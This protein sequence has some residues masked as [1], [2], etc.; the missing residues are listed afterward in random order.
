MSMWENFKA[1]DHWF[2]KRFFG[3]IFL[4]AITIGLIFLIDKGLDK[5]PE[6]K[7]LFIEYGNGFIWFLIAGTVLSIFTGTFYFSTLDSW[8]DETEKS[9]TAASLNAIIWSIFWLC[10]SI[11]SAWITL[12]SKLLT[13]PVVIFILLLVVIPGFAAFKFSHGVRLQELKQNDEEKAR[14]GEKYNDCDA[15]NSNTH[16]KY[17]SGYYGLICLPVYLISLPLIYLFK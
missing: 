10:W 16:W 15:Y 3:V 13:I 9:I 5:V 7:N 6:I 11:Y 14:I 8:E 2:E 4:F 1:N 12:H 17:Y